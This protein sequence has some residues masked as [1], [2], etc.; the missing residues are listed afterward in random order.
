MPQRYRNRTKQS[1]KK[2]E[3]MRKAKERKRLE[4]TEAPFFF[5]PPLVRRRI[6]I[7]DYDF[8]VVRH[9]IVC[10]KSGR[11]DS[12]EICVDGKMQPKKMGWSAVCNLQRQAFVRV[13]RYE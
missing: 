3:L 8:G 10:Y 1:S 5:D 11:V 13:G 4:D 7:E 6:I 9:E 2:M 12:Y